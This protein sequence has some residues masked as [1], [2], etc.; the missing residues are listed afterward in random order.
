MTTLSFSLGSYIV[1]LHAVAIACTLEISSIMASI[2]HFHAW[3]SD[4]NVSSYH[5]PLFDRLPAFVGRAFQRRIQTAILF[6]FVDLVCVNVSH[7]S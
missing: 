5:I 6:E 2:L 4:S 7:A 3:F 1:G